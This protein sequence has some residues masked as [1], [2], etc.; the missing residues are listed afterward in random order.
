MSA[1]AGGARREWGGCLPGTPD[2]P[3][4]SSPAVELWSGIRKGPPRKLKF[5]QPEAVVE[6]LKSNL[7]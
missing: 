5:P 2:A 1:G 3:P 4:V 6:A 7:G